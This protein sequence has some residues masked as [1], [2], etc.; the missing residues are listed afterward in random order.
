MAQPTKEPDHGA[1]GN[2]PLP[3][4]VLFV[5]AAILMCAATALFLAGHWLLA[6]VPVALIA[7]EFVW[8]RAE[9]RDVPRAEGCARCARCAMTKVQSTADPACG[10]R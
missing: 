3:W 4:I 9:M 1:A 7:F 6:L 5:P 8:A 10:D 2:G